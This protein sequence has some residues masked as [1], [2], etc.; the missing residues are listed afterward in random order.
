MKNYHK[1]NLH[2]K[3]HY[4][5]SGMNQ[6]ESF[7]RMNNMMHIPW[8]GYQQRWAR[9]DVDSIRSSMID[10]HNQWQHKREAFIECGKRAR[11]KVESLYT[12][13]AVTAVVQKIISG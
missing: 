5:D 1:S 4:H 6:S 7:P 3:Y 10:A 13:K 2:K 12:H 9:L 8:Y 11:T